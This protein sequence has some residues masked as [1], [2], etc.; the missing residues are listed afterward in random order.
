MR[1]KVVYIEPVDYFP[2]E[3]R[4]EYHLGEYADKDIELKVTVETKNNTLKAEGIEEIEK[5]LESLDKDN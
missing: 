5:L 1:K 3:I 4:K 2:K